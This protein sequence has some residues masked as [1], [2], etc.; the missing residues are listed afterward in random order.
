MTKPV[1]HFTNGRRT[2]GRSGRAHADQEHLTFDRIGQ[3]VP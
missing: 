2:G 1:N 3:K